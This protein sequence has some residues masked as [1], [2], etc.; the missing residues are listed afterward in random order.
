MS[1]ILCLR[2]VSDTTLERLLK[3]PELIHALV[4]NEEVENDGALTDEGLSVDLDKAWHAIHFLLTGSVWE[5]EGR[6]AFLLVGGK[7]IGDIDVGYGP[8]RGLTAAETCE[9]ATALAR[10]TVQALAARFDG[11]KLDVAEIYPQIWVRDGQDGL[12]YITEYYESLRQ[13]VATACSKKMGM[14]VFIT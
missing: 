2:T 11:T 9:I 8:A 6:E 3:K 14:L 4:N 7:T 1:M 5:G 12:E 13:F 10:I